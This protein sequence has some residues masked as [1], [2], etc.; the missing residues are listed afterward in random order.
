MALGAE[1]RDVLV[2]VI[3]QGMLLVAVGGLVCSRCLRVHARDGEFVVRSKRHESVTFALV[4]LVLAVVR[5]RCLL[6]PRATSDE[7]RSA[8]GA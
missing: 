7:G 4:P 8:G 3:K 6:S 5:I 2:M 1:A